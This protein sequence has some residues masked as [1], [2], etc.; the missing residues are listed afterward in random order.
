M[1]P[2]NLAIKIIK[3]DIDVVGY[4]LGGIS[5]ARKT[6]LEDGIH[7]LGNSI[8]TVEAQK[9]VARTSKIGR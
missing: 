6:E 1:N 5:Q 4:L 7:N 3:G 8:Q 2:A 9:V